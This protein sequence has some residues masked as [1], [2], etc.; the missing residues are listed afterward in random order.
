MQQNILICRCVLHRSCQLALC[1]HAVLQPTPCWI[2]VYSC[3]MHRCTGVLFCC[4]HQ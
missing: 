3:I 4:D 2:C 1:Q